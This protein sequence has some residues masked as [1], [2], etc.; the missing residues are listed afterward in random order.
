MLQLIF[1]RLDYPKKMILPRIIFS[2]ADIYGGGNQP[3][4]SEIA[5][6]FEYIT[7][8]NFLHTQIKSITA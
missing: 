1:E 8:G 5:K 6:C 2:F 3:Q 7:I 4:V